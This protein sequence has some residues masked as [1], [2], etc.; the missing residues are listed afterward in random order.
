[1]QERNNARKKEKS[2]AAGERE[3][4]AEDLERETPSGEGFSILPMAQTNTS[5]GMKIITYIKPKND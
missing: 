3:R 1:M 4:G 5:R 2:R